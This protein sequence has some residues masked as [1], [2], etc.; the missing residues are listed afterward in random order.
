[1]KQ[2]L[3]IFSLLLTLLAFSASAVAQ[4]ATATKI[5][6]ESKAAFDKLK[7]FS[8]DFTYSLQNP[9][10]TRTNVT[11][12]GK[13]FYSQGKYTAIMD[14]Q[15]IYCDG[16]YIWNHIPGED[17]ED[18]ELTILDYDPE[19]GFNIESIF[20][21]YENGSKA[22]YDGPQTIEGK[23]M[24]KIYMAATDK[25]L[26]FNQ[27]RLWINRNTKLLEKAVV[28]NRRQIDTIYQFKNMKTNQNLPPSTFSFDKSNFKGEI[29]DETEG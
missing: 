6:N 24:H 28:T 27:A 16:N 9:S 18:A 17:P 10:N 8:A 7:D 19:E 23:P 1:M 22:R 13:I 26:E 11:K 21:L 25:E 4:D 2:T 20:K 29:Y 3:T 14:G 15:E 5:L 12:S